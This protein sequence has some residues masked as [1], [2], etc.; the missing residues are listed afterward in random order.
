MKML[1]WMTSTVRT[2]PQPDN[3]TSKEKS[4][5]DNN[6][7]VEIA[8]IIDKSGSMYDLQSDVVGG[9]NSTLEE[10]KKNPN[11]HVTITLFDNEIARPVDRVPSAAVSL[12]SNEDYIPGGTTALLDAVGDTVSHIEKT[13]AALDEKDRAERILV[14]IITDGLENASQEYSYETV[15]KIIAEKEDGKW[16]FIFLGANIDA[17]TEASKIGIRASRA[18]N[19]YGDASGVAATASVMCK[20]VNTLS[21]SEEI[22]EASLFEDIEQDWASRS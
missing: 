17:A 19:W 11:A 4:K 15:K 9:V 6:A 1:E 10:A 18:A 3:K 5:K 14:T 8:I 22:D 16:E 21:M 7:Q 13:Q 20:A 2:Q 12:F